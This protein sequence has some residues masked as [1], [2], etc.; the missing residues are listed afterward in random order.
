M[1]E[2]AVA[3]AGG[4]RS[5]NGECGSRRP[6]YSHGAYLC[7]TAPCCLKCL[8]LVTSDDHRVPLALGRLYVLKQGRHCGVI[9][10]LWSGACVGPED[11]EHSSE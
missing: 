4:V 7:P 1:A 9:P 3:G 2:R 5:R 11:I 8:A 10:S 6:A